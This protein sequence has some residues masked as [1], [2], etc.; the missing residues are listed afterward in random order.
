MK[1]YDE[2]ETK[3]K[4]VNEVFKFNN[5]M[6]C[7]NENNNKQNEDTKS[8]NNVDLTSL[9]NEIANLKE[10]LVDKKVITKNNDEIYHECFDKVVGCIRNNIPLMLVGGAGTG[11]NYTLE[12]V[13]K[14][15]NKDFYIDNAITQE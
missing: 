9:L 1:E 15:L 4:C 2:L 7:N 11:K 13:A 14:S 10:L 3:Q 8:Y 6:F 5:G 12:Q